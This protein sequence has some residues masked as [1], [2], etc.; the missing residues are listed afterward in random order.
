M[1][2]GGD[3]SVRYELR[4]PAGLFR[5]AKVIARELGYGSLGAWLRVLLTS[6]LERAMAPRTDTTI[7]P[8]DPQ[9]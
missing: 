1:S 5:T 7:F 2:S 8:G 9:S 6:E 3:M 4:I